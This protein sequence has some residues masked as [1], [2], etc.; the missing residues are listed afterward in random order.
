[1]TSDAVTTLGA[2]VDGAVRRIEYAYDTAG[3]PTCSP[4]TTP[5]PAAWS[6]TRS[7]ISS[8]A[9]PAHGRVP[10]P[11]G[12]GEH[13]HDAQGPVRLH[14]ARRPHNYSRPTSMT[15]PN[16]RVVRYLYDDAG[17]G[18]DSASA[19]SR[20]SPTARPGRSSWRRTRTSAWAR[21][22]RRPSPRPR[23]SLDLRPP[24]RRRRGVHRRRRPVHRA[25]PLR[26]V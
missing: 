13:L 24:G 18:I 11:R 10:G 20:R 8:T 16:G 25:R 2:G 15:Y 5:R 23:S 6:S 14:D 7:T 12:R 22:S 26:P 17:A 21:S 3:R 19:G 1:M 4:A 9:R